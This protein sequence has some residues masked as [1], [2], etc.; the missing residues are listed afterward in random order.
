LQNSQLKEDQEAAISK[1]LQ[2]SREF[3]KM[4]SEKEVV[5]KEQVIA[6]MMKNWEMSKANNRHL[7]GGCHCISVMS[8]YNSAGNYSVIIII[9]ITVISRTVFM[10]LLP[11]QSHCKSSSSLCN[12][13]RTA[14]KPSSKSQ[15]CL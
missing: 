5:S 3:E 7:A 12:E 15:V 13:C 2:S 6:E 8:H 9:I 4:L 1:L 10:M 11:W 14:Y